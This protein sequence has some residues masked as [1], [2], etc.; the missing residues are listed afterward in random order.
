MSCVT[1]FVLM[2]VLDVLFLKIVEKT[3]VEKKNN[4]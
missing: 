1:G 2:K 3:I 4:K